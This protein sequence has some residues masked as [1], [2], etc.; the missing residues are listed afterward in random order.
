MNPLQFIPI[1]NVLYGIH[2]M[3]NVKKSSLID[4]IMVQVISITLGAFLMIAFNANDMRQT[5][6]TY[7]MAILFTSLLMTGA[8]YRRLS[9]RG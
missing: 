1:D 7:S 4:M 6:L 5:E 9:D 8:V 3:T 2:D